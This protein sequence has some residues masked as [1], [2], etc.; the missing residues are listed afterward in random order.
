MCRHVPCRPVTQW[1][2][3]EEAG[4]GRGACMMN[5]LPGDT[6]AAGPMRHTLSF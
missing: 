6:D 5:E 3:M 4:A 2:L 1:V